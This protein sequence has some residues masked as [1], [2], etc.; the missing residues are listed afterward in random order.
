MEQT[1]LYSVRPRKPIKDLDGVPFIRTP[2]SLQLT[3]EDVLK[4]LDKGSVYRYFANENKL[5]KVTVNNLDRL[6]NAKFM[7]EA[8]YEKFLA[9]EL[10]KDSGTVVEN[11]PTPVVE[12]KKE[13]V[14]EEPKVEE[15]PAAP[16][17]EEVKPEEE[18]VVEEA[19][20]E[21]NTEENSVADSAVENNVGD[22]AEESVEIDPANNDTTDSETTESEPAEEAYDGEED[23]DANAE[24]KDTNDKHQYRKN[25][26]NHHKGSKR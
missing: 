5:E 25:S 20:A 24:S 19:K 1:Y 16:V 11:I 4:C 3:K 15:A 14:K 8:T 18:H 7:D 6:H 22:Q 23:S 17:V 10:G 26:N 13:E 12:E 21:D 2:K 9:G